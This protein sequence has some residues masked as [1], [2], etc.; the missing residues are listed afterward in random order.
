MVK[1]S[2]A[3]FPNSEIR[4]AMIDCFVKRRCKSNFYASG[5][6]K[7]YVKTTNFRKYYRFSYILAKKMSEREISA[8]PALKLPLDER[9]KSKDR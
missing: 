3:N 5:V 4:R 2:L 8:Y 7:R 1:K 6:N 9:H